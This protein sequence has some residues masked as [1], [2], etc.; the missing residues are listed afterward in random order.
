M[1][2][3]LSY[4]GGPRRARS[5]NGR[6]RVAPD[7][8]QRPPWQEKRGR[9]EVPESAPPQRDKNPRQPPAWALGGP[10]C[11]ANSSRAGLV[12]DS[13]V[14]GR[15][16][17]WELPPEWRSEPPSECPGRARNSGAAATGAGSVGGRRC[18]GAGAAAGAGSLDGGGRRRRVVLGGR[19]RAQR[20][21]RRFAH[22]QVR[23]G[24]ST[25][26]RRGVASIASSNGEIRS[27]RPCRTAVPRPA[28]ATGRRRAGR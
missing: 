2:Y 5:A 6:K 4:C 17:R 7:I 3:Q 24:S 1:L 12:V 23:G 21:G 16:G 26:A 9:R 15:P 14:V 11:W 27:P 19:R 22:R 8:G 28:S 10:I 20:G 25:T 18:G 13:G